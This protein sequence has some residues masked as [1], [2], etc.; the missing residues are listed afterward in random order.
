[1]RRT[2]RSRSRGNGPTVV[3]LAGPNGAGKSTTAPALLKGALGVTE[4][5]DADAIARGLS[6]FRPE[7]AALSAGKMMLIRLQ[8]LASQRISFA[9]ESTLA[10]RIFG[11]RLAELRQ[12]GYRVHIVFLWLPSADFA[13]DRVADRVRMGGHD[14][15]EETVRRRYTAGL[16]NF[17]S[18][19]QPLAN[20]WRMYDNSRR[21]GPRL[22]ATGRASNVTRVVDSKTW[23]LIRREVKHGTE[24]EGE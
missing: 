23:A 10:S 24:E 6:A 7:R 21:S 14:V 17:F 16:G 1:V 11:R 2:Q 3:V 18:I 20:T 8:E 12:S 9:F 5:V 22:I 13:V 4:F 19:Y 15:P